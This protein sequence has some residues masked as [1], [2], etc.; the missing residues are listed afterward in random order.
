MLIKL[1]VWLI[2][3]LFINQS[4]H[5]GGDEL[6]NLIPRHGHLNRAH[7]PGGNFVG[8]EEEHHIVAGEIDVVGEEKRVGENSGLLLQLL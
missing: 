6:V 1:C 7:G 2:N 3:S 5:I 4:S 8:V